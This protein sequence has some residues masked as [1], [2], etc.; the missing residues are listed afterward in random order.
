MA[1]QDLNWANENDLLQ[2][3][4]AR[5]RPQGI[6][7]TDWNEMMLPLRDL[8]GQNQGDTAPDESAIRN[9]YNRMRDQLARFP[10]MQGLQGALDQYQPATLETLKTFHPMVNQL[11]NARL[12]KALPALM[13]QGGP[14]PASFAQIYKPFEPDV[15][16]NINRNPDAAA[17]WFAAPE[18]ARQR[19][20]RGY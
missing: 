13:Q 3:E 8:Y 5:N 20:M 1:L 12:N 19:M 11:K 2:W 17:R 7:A 18:E 9:A 15:W 16:E 6:G 4:F 14:T 10:V